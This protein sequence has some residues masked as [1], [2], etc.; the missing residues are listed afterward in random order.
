MSMRVQVGGW[1]AA[2]KES[3]LLHYRFLGGRE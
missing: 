2:A 1:R 3:A